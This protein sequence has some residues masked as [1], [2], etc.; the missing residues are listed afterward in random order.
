MGKQVSLRFTNK[1]GSV[2]ASISVL[3]FKEDNTFIVYTPQLDIS[4]YGN[5]Y[6]EALNSFE[7]SLEMFLD[8]TTNKNTLYKTLSDLG[9]KPIAS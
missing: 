9:W 3:S 1:A 7:N 4:G 8:Y 6:E 2:V 5:T